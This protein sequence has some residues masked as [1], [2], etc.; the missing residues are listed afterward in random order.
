MRRSRWC[1][2]SC[3]AGEV[4]SMGADP[5]K[6]PRFED[7]QR[8]RLTAFNREPLASAGGVSRVYSPRSPEAL[9]LNALVSRA[10]VRMARADRLLF[11]KKGL[12]AWVK[13]GEY[14]RGLRRLV[15]GEP[16]ASCPYS[17][18]AVRRPSATR[19]SL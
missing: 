14:P 4:Y 18:H 17:A 16:A 12:P 7:T 13:S 9:R 2:S 6:G 3:P 15:T 5:G 8:L 19:V 1:A 10:A 11:T